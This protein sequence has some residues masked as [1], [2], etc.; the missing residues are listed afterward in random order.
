MYYVNPEYFPPLF[1]PFS[2]LICGLT[3][4]IVTI[5]SPQV[6]ELQPKH[7][8]MIFYLSLAAIATVASLFLNK[9]KDKAKSMSINMDSRD[10]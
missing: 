7:V 4:R 5:A 9:P 8:P 2:F 1:V 3:A 10:E 6:A